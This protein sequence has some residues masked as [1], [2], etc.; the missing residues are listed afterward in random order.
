MTEVDS[1]QDVQVN[2]YTPAH[3]CS[4]RFFFYFTQTAQIKWRKNICGY[5]QLPKKEN[6]KLQW[7]KD[8]RHPELIKFIHGIQSNPHFVKFFEQLFPSQTHEH[9]STSPIHWQIN[10]HICSAGDWEGINLLLSLPHW[11]TRIHKWTDTLAHTHSLLYCIKARE[12]ERT[13]GKQANTHVNM[14]GH[15]GICIHRKHITL[16]QRI[17]I[18]LF[19]KMT[20]KGI[21]NQHIKQRNHTSEKKSNIHPH[22]PPAPALRPV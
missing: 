2:K 4:F 3:K 16:Q 19:S 7:H 22:Y 9:I 17:F 1:C 8:S 11:H 15:R 12:H 6:I 10:P 21:T 14:N 5:R 13:C 20:V 18:G